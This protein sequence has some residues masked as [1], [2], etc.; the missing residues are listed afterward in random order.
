MKYVNHGVLGFYLL[1][2]KIHGC[3]GFNITWLNHALLNS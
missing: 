1:Q 2:S 3:Y